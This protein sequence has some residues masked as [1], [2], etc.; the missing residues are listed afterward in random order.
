[1]AEEGQVISCHTVQGWTE[2]LERGQQSNK[3]VFNLHRSIFSVFLCVIFEILG[4]WK[5]MVL[6]SSD[7]WVKLRFL[8]YIYI[9]MYMKW[10]VEAVRDGVLLALQARSI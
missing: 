5:S 1:M 3:L 7:Y 2:Q 10:S 9:Y 6:L 8:G 4:Y